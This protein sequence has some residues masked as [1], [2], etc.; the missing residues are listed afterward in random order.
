[1]AIRV[2][3]KYVLKVATNQEIQMPANAQV[4]SVQGQNN[5]AV[6]WCL[7]DKADDIVP[8]T[9]TVI[10][11]GD[12]FNADYCEYLGTFQTDGGEF[13]GH[14]FEVLEAAKAWRPG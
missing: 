13:V 6:M 12:S 11:T 7:C 1:M 5:D 8:R 10:T 2:I 9:F 14:V 3:Y 4:L